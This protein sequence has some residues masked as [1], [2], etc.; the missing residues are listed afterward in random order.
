[1]ITGGINGVFIYKFDYQGKY[2]P[3]LAAK[4]DPYGTYIKIQLINKKEVDN[5]LIWC[6]GL[7]ID[8]KANIIIS[9]DW[10]DISINQ[11]S[12]NGRLVC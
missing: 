5:M 10:K 11:L 4:V 12:H 3:S 8:K 7:K 2:K 9:W 6:K 1:L